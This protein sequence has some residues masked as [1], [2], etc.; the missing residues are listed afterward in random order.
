MQNIIPLWWF[1]NTR[2]VR[3][4]NTVNQPPFVLS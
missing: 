3:L 1:V 2:R 4:F